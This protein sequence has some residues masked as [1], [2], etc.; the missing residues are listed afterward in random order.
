MTHLVHHD[1]QTR[2]RPPASTRCSWRG[3]GGG[4]WPGGQW[5]TRGRL[6]AATSCSA[7]AR[8]WCRKEPCR[9]RVALPQPVLIEWGWGML[10]APDVVP[11]PPENSY[12]GQIEPPP[13]LLAGLQSVKRQFFYAMPRSPPSVMM[14]WAGRPRMVPGHLPSEVAKQPP[15][16]GLTQTRTH[17]PPWPESADIDQMCLSGGRNLSGVCTDENELDPNLDLAWTRPHP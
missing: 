9:W 1:R 3:R 11:S 2:C 14:T 7:A 17:P 10:I 15:I 8:Q 6:Q 13:A 5:G 12:G 16:G 4:Q